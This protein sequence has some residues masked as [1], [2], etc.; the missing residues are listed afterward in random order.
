VPTAHANVRLVRR[1][2][3]AWFGGGADLTPYY[4]FEDDCRLFHGALRK[5]CEEHVPGSHARH[6]RTADSY[7]FLKNRE[8]HRGV[9]GIFYE[10]LGGD[11]EAELR[12]S[13]AVARAFLEAY[14]A[15]ATRRK[16]LPF[17][18]EERRWQELRRGRYVE[19]NL[20]YDRGTAFGLESGGRTE[21]VLASLPPRVRWP[22]HHVPAPGSREQALLDVLRSPRDWV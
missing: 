7:F 5:A 12:F 6:K 4:L 20:L 21:S 19:F 13:V 8:E 10:D 18:E 22:Y 14:L 9:G 1:G 2:E 11:L 15:I 3:V 17:G 16:D